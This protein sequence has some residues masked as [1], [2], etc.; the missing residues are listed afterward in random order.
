[1]DANKVQSLLFTL[2]DGT[3]YFFPV[4]APAV[5]A[6]EIVIKGLEASGVIALP[7]EPLNVDQVRA[8]A[9]G[10]EAAKASI[11]TEIRSLGNGAEPVS[12]QLATADTDPNGTVL[13]S[14]VGK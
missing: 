3:A 5:S 4:L 10:I 8:Q 1:M 11:A 9:A 13:L 14:T 2:A 7:A 6:V 12:P